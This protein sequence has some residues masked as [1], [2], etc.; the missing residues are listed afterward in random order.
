MHLKK[1]NR[2]RS[3]KRD[4]NNRGGTAHANEQEIDTKDTLMPACYRFFL[5][6]FNINTQLL[7]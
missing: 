4:N 5:L 1:Y 2:G 6:S 3:C 7:I